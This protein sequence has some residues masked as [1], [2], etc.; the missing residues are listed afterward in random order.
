M[1]IYR[2]LDKKQTLICFYL[3]N[4]YILTQLMFYTKEEKKGILCLNI[5]RC[6]ILLCTKHTSTVYYLQM[7]NYHAKSL[8]IIFISKSNEE[9]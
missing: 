8:A 2:Y 4:G 1:N 7:D 3:T 6:F 9:P 5:Q